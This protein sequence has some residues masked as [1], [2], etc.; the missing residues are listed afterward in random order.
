M[1]IFD[2]IMG[3]CIGYFVALGIKEI[4]LW[5]LYTIN[6]ILGGV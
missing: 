2:I 6:D 4:L 1:D 5:F 3:C